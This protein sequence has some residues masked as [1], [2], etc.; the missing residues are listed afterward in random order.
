MQKEL[1]LRG[2]GAGNASQLF[3]GLTGSCSLTSPGRELCQAQLS[4]SCW[5]RDKSCLEL[6][7]SSLPWAAQTGTGWDSPAPPWD[8]GLFQAFCLRVQ[9]PSPTQWFPCVFNEEFLA[10][11]TR[12]ERLSFCFQPSSEPRELLESKG[13]GVVSPELPHPGEHSTG[14]THTAPV[15][16]FSENGALC[17]L[18]RHLITHLVLIC[19]LLSVM[20]WVLLNVCRA[21]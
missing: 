8:F 11:S 1:L 2:P 9:I 14:T 3:T 5:S 7:S 21:I 13:S 12:T 17:V 10:E 20:V 15:P 16:V 19:S 18:S 4:T 6:T